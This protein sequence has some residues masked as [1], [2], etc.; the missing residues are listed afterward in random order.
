[1][2]CRFRQKGQCTKML[3]ALRHSIII[4]IRAKKNK[5]PTIIA[6]EFGMSNSFVLENNW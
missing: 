6:R 4:I 1:M 5:S 3:K 2:F